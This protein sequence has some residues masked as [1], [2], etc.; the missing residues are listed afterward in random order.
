MISHTSLTIVTNQ[1]RNSAAPPP[2]CDGIFIIF[3]SAMEAGHFYSSDDEDALTGKSRRGGC[4][5]TNNM[6]EQK[7]DAE[8]ERLL[9]REIEQSGGISCCSIRAICNR[10]PDVFGGPRSDLRKAA[11]NKL[12]HWRKMCEREY[13]DRVIA[14]FAAR[15]P[16]SEG[17]I[18]DVL[19]SP[20]SHS[21]RPRQAELAR[22]EQAAM[23]RS[24]GG[25]VPYS[26]PAP[27]SALQGLPLLANGTSSPEQ[28][29][30]HDVLSDPTRFGK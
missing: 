16:R 23:I 19:I 11:S 3:K 9:L 25:I 10:H 21:P 2:Q 17:S 13:K 7:L 27:R 1:E 6:V 30:I 26:P 14:A 18:S 15:I 28:M 29:Y 24:P 12:T 4:N 8:A 20:L 5:K 22:Y